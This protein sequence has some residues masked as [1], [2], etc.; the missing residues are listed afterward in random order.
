VTD[1]GVGRV[2]RELRVRNRWRQADLARRAR[3]SASTVS[4]VER[5]LL[6]GVSL[7]RL[8]RILEAVGA[9]LDVVARWS[10]GDLERLMNARHS[11]MHELVATM[12][13]QLPAWEI[14]PEVSFSVYGERG[15]IDVIAW[16]AASR[17]ALVVEL[18]SEIVDINDLMAKADQRRRLAPTIAAARGWRPANV[19][20][21]VLV[22]ESRTNRRRLA[23]HRTILRSA[24]PVDGRSMAAWLRHPAGAPAALSFLTNDQLVSP[25]TSL[26][27]P[28]RVLPARPRSKAT[29]QSGHAAAP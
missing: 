27:R 10:G 23:T 14:A 21:W 12:F 15:I 8:R 11:A 28:R 16:H 13:G 6:R 18:K 26:V 7:D 1:Q 24:F 22:A 4:R 3:V 5:G 17:T 9:R 20:I 19:A 2:V 25:R 29:T